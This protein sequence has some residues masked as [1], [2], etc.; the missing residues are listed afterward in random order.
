MAAFGAKGYRNGNIIDISTLF[1]YRGISYGA[2]MDDGAITV[3][4]FIKKYSP[5]LKG[6]SISQHLVE[7]CYGPLCPPFQCL[8]KLA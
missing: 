2:G 6:G 4:N 8:S 3:P 7:V 5:K 1:E